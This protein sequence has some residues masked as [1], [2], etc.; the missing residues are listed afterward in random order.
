MQ[1]AQRRQS[2]QI[3]DQTA[4]EA[5]ELGARNRLAEASRSGGGLFSR[6]GGAAGVKDTL[7]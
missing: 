4:E 3:E 5:R 7:G 2:K 6:K 1:K